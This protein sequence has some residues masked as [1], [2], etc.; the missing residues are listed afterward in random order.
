VRRAAA[1]AAAAILAALAWPELAR[2]AAERRLGDATNAFR[3]LLDRASD[4]DTGRN[5]IVVGQAGLAVA[6]ALPGDP[7]P[8]IL[9]GS[10][11]LVTNQP[12][13]ALETYREAFAT[14]ERS[15]I[16]LNLGRAYAMLGRRENAERAFVRAGW[17]SPEIL[18]SLPEAMRDTAAAEVKRLTRD[19]YGGRLTEPPP[20][21]PDERR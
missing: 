7:R 16:D 10:S 17:V 2:Y 1:I 6:G 21:P 15:E 9:G 20:L 18:D 5:L 11:F 3:V 8:W 4:P 12:Q 13:P 19:L 14:G